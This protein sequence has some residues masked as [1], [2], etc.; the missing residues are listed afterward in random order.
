MHYFIKADRF[1]Y[2]Y[3]TKAAGYLEIK[4]G[5]FGEYVE[6]AP[7]D[8]EIHDFSGYSIAP[9]LV[10]THIHGFAGADVMDVDDAGLEKISK[11]L[12]KAGVTSWLATPLTGKHE[13]L[14]AVCEQIAEQ[15]SKLS[16]AKIQGIFLEGPYFTE[17]HKG[18]QN[19]VYMTAP[20]L[21]EFEDWNEAAQ[22]LI[23]KIALA[24]ER[25]GAVEFTRALTERGI[26]VALGHSNASYEQARE[27]VA[28]GASLFVHTYNGMSPLNHREPG[29][30]GAAL[31]L[32]NTYA[33][34]ICDGHHLHPA[35]VKVMLDSK[36][37]EHCV[38]I[39]DAMRAAGMPDG[40]YML[41][42][43][44]VLVKE[45]AA[46]LRDGDSLAGSILQLKDA[47]K[48]V[49]D[50]ELATPEQAIMMATMTAAR[51][52]GIDDVAGKIEKGRSADFT[53]FDSDMCLIGI[54]LN[55]ERRL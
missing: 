1:F 14:R 21:R 33:E 27:C 34:L 25:E 3:E 15:K 32:K 11:A 9:G 10:D 4:A 40:E 12:V 52:S 17:R 41:G 42:E 22:G 45:G 6:K 47:V 5:K 31:T 8:A 18:A 26:K 51:S 37:A 46:R 44:P 24:P 13:Q 48:N 30:V 39:T 23:K 49:V 35:A 28:A 55:G 2:P 38:L 7:E 43:F 16:G 29:M 53:I 20:S 54:S 19:P 36:G 50:W